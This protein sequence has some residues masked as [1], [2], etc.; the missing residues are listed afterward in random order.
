M[1]EI[2]FE[3]LYYALKQAGV[4]GSKKEFWLEMDIKD[5]EEAGAFISKEIWDEF[6]LKK[7]KG[8]VMKPVD[9]T[10]KK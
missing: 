8:I 1:N 5:L 3:R 7:R 10:R 4:V 2:D 9:Y 6:I